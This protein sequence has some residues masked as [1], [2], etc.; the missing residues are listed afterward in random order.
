MR[1]ATE[2]MVKLFGR[3]NRKWGCFFVMERATGSEFSPGFFQSY[4]GINH[5]D[6][7]DTSEQ[8]INKLGRNTAGHKINGKRN[9]RW[10]QHYKPKLNKY[11]ARIRQ[12]LAID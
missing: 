10:C 7:I 11:G 1:A 9:T 5:V 4:P 12:L 2:T 3:T 8:I 6:N